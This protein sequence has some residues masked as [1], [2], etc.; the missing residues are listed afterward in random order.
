MVTVLTGKV[1]VG[2]NARTSFTAA[3]AE[4]LRVQPYMIKVV[5]GDTDL[6]P[7]DRG[8]F[9]SQSTPQMVPQLRRA[10]ATMREALVDMAAE[11]LGVS[12]DSLTV[13]EGKVSG[14]GG[15]MTFGELVGDKKITNVIPREVA[16]TPPDKWTVILSPSQCAKAAR[17]SSGAWAM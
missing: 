1:E 16:L 6:V 8:T 13:A 3:V 17:G 10:A 11:K 5:M 14:C 7:Y 15:T 9:G 4:E 12:R 2:Q